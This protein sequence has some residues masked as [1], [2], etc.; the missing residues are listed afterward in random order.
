MRELK[1]SSVA[2]NVN[3]SLYGPDN[4]ITGIF[5]FLNSASP[6]DAVIRYW[7]DENGIKLA[8]EK[9]I[10]C[11][12][13]EEAHGRSIEY[14][15]KLGIS[16]VIVDKIEM[17]NAYAIK[18]AINNFASDAKKIVVTGT[19]GKS[20]TAHLLFNI[21]NKVGYTTYSNTD[22]KSE[23]NTL[24][25]PMVSKQ[26]AEFGKP[27]EYLV[28]EVSEVQGLPDRL[29]ENHAYIM[30]DAICPDIVVVTNI[31]LDHVNLVNSINEMFKETSGAI[32]ALKKGYAILNST[33]PL[34][35]K[36]KDFINPDVKVIH[37][38]KGEVNFNSD[39]IYFNSNLIIEKEKLPFKS[40]HFIYNIMAAVGA[41]SALEIPQNSIKK[42]IES[43]KPLKRRFSILNKQ[44]LI[45]DDF[46]H[47]PDGIMA[48]IKN[49]ISNLQGNI[50]IVSAI[51]G[52]RGID[53]NKFNAEA[54]VK[55]L[56]CEELSNLK[57][58]LII[59]SS[60]DIVDNANIVLDVEKEVFVKILE[61][62]GLN[63]IF[64]DK[65]YD[66]IKYS[67]LSA[68]KDDTILLIG[69]QGMDPASEVFKKVL[70]SLNQ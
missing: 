18:W 56:N 59:T 70:S 8:A 11:I 24:I 7:I 46:A 26:I 2:K 30:T 41:A 55:G 45:I 35:C 13:T 32:K 25:D 68:K 28:L 53:I 29:M 12:I 9:E 37:F 52:S 27:I 44:P 51:R 14:S 40:K 21:L 62:E 61:D 6:G 15:D 1:A 58:Q 64:K 47:N 69:A 42:G 43:Y 34:V 60:N 50:I 20:T 5:N 33:D 48:T 4:N 67:F 23:F 65:L 22:A 54:I 39:G 17:A 3:G 10:S 31:A 19:N 36:M 16:L 66:A 63:Y 57:Y 38:G 49:T